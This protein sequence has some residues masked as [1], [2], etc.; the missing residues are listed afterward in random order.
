MCAGGGF[1]SSSKAPRSGCYRLR[2]NVPSQKLNIYLNNKGRIIP[3]SLLTND[4]EMQSLL[5]KQSRYQKTPQ[6]KYIL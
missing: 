6:H 1:V 2:L 4:E 3:T 5:S